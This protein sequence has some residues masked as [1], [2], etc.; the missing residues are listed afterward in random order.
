MIRALVLLASL[1]LPIA[2]HAQEAVSSEPPQRI[3][4]VT[5]L[6]GEKCPAPSVPNEVVVCGAV[7]EQ[8]RIPKQ[9]RDVP[10]QGPESTAW[11]VKVDRV[12]D[13]NRKILPGSCT[14]IGSNGQTG[15][16]MKAAEAWAA[17]RRAKANGYE[18]PN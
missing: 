11:G 3:R 13:D 4:N 6:P 14:P 10:K 8:F 2:A 17:E 12:M 16:A 18:Q 7:D 1:T 9:F 5:L 15:C